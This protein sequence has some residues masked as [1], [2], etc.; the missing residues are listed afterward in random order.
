MLFERGQPELA[1]EYLRSALQ[2]QPEH[3]EARAML[4]RLGEAPVD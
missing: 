4:E 3:E 1:E 2:F